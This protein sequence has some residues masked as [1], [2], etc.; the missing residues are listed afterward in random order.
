MGLSGKTALITGSSKGIGRG[1]AVKLAEIGCDLA[2]RYSADQAGADDVAGKIRNQ[3]QKAIAVKADVGKAGPVREMFETVLAKFSRLDILV[4][5]P[6]T[7]VWAL[8]LEL[9]E[10]DWG[11]VIDT[12]LKGCFL[13]TQLAG[14]RI[15]ERRGGRT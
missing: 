10:E 14:R 8:L 12:N 4:N 15:K 13:C 2:V 3:G 6:G 11:T 9:S 5:H 1:I 7:P